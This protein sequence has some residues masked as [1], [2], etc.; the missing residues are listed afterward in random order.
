MTLIQSVSDQ[1]LL[2]HGIAAAITAIMFMRIVDATHVGV[3]LLCMLCAIAIRYMLYV[4]Y[5]RAQ[6]DLKADKYWGRIIAISNF[7]IGAA[8][9]WAG[10]AF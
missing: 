6:A 5:K 7:L 8:W 9:G 1:G 10:Y 3:W 2:A 4:A